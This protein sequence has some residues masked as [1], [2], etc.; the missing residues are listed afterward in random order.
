M[1]DMIEST[2]LEL[3]KLNGK[4][5][6]N[7]I[8]VTILTCLKISR[9]IPKIILVKH[10]KIIINE[11]FLVTQ[12]EAWYIKLSLV[13]FSVRQPIVN[14]TSRLFWINILP[15]KSFVEAF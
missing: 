6:I 8:I 9:K 7:N 13:D 5:H 3:E 1:D 4:Q 2:I 11:M 15:G 14:T 12:D 10:F